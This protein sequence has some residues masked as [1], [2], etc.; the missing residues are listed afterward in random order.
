MILC[1]NV[2]G[3]A[4]FHHDPVFGIMFLFFGVKNIQAQTAQLIPLCPIV[5]QAL[6]AHQSIKLDNYNFAITT[7][8]SGKITANL[9]HED[10]LVHEDELEENCMTVYVRTINGKTIRIKCHREQLK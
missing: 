1:N 5:W 4:H 10:D 2:E 3:K 8:D 9:E 7:E 6:T